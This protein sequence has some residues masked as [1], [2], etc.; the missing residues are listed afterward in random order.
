MAGD[1]EP[2]SILENPGVGKASKMLV[3]LARVRTL[4]VVVTGHDRRRGI[5]LD[6]HILD[7]HQRGLELG[8]GEVGEK[9]A[10]IADFSVVLGVGEAVADHGGD[11]GRVTVHLRLVP[12]ALERDE[13]GRGL[14]V[15]GIL[16]RLPKC[17]GR[18]E[19]S[20]KQ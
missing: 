7:V 17:A 10:A 19:Q 20:A 5:D 9:F 11:G 4:S 14:G 15:S 18:Q 2:F 12:H 13:A 16:R 8:V 3:R 6:V 1:A